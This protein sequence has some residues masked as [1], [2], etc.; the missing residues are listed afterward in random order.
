MSNLLKS[1]TLLLL[2]LALDAGLYYALIRPEILQWGVTGEEAAA[3]MPG[4]ELAPYASSTRAIEIN[5]PRDVVWQWLVQLGADRGGFY[6]YT[7]LENLLGYD[8]GNMITIVPEYQDMPVGRVV[9]ATAG[10]REVPEFYRWEVMSAEPGQYFVL[11]HWGA[12]MLKDAGPDKTKLIVR[13]HGWDTPTLS[14]KAGYFMTMPLHYI[15]ERRMLMGL[16]ARAEAGQGVHMSALPDY[17]WA[18]GCLLSAMGVIVLVFM[19]RKWWMAIIAFGF[20]ALWLWVSLVSDAVPPYPL[21]LLAGVVVAV[22]WF[23]AANKRR[24][25]LE[26]FAKNY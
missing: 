25:R 26:G 10:G 14:D 19:S 16:K 13:T 18:G 23:A 2:I 4:D 24:R 17:L 9:P 22:L 11:K 12:F 15:M 20:S 7:F 6:S 1:L 5:A 3:T 21:A 8:T